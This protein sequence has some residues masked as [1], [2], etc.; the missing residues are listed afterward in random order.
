MESA[1]ALLGK[2]RPQDGALRAANAKSREVAN[3][4]EQTPGT[5]QKGT[6]RST[7]GKDVTQEQS[8]GRRSAFWGC[9]R[10]VFLN[11]VWA[12]ETRLVR[13]HGK[14]WG[15]GK[16][17]T[18]SKSVQFSNKQT[19]TGISNGGAVEGGAGGCTRGGGR[20]DG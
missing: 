15:R 3:E 20:W 8:R 17:R 13:E 1:G 5:I 9:W 6:R 4:M 16:G 11:Y 19:R 10:K 18:F 14:N 7:S 2:R 12:R